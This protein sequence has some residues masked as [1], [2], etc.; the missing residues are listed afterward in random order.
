[1]N[2]YFSVRS[3]GLGDNRR[4]IVDMISGAVA[5]SFA[6]S[7]LDVDAWANARI[8]QNSTLQTL[9]DAGKIVASR[10]YSLPELQRLW[11]SLS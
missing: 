7:E 4:E 2:N 1:M 9:I 3:S 5:S 6:H 10:E 8:A 11:A